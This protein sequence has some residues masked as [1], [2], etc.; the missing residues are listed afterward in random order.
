MKYIVVKP[1]IILLTVAAILCFAAA[2]PLLFI[3]GIIMS[4]FIVCSGV[5]CILGLKTMGKTQISVGDEG[6]FGKA[7]GKPFQIR[8]SEIAIVRIDKLN[9]DNSVKLRIT[10]KDK[11]EFYLT[12]REPEKIRD[13][14]VGNMQHLKLM[15]KD[16]ELA[17]LKL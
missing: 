15:P 16:D 13:I 6:I 14:I 12:L 1:P 17:P 9:R 5:T 3:S 10:T 11:S 8:Y 7:D 4:A 2:I